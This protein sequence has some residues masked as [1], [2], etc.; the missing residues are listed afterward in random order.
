[1]DIQSPEI[2]TSTKEKL[3]QHAG[4]ACDKKDIAE[5]VCN[6]VKQKAHKLKP[7]LAQGAQIQEEELVHLMRDIEEYK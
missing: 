2:P 7:F 6:I 1:M 5:T 4:K 3:L